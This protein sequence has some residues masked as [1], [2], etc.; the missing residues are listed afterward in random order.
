[1][2][3]AWNEYSD[4]HINTVPVPVQTGLA[5]GMVVYSWGVETMEEVGGEGL[6]SLQNL[7]FPAS[8]GAVSI[9]VLGLRHLRLSQVGPR[10]SELLSSGPVAARMID[11]QV[12]G[13][14]L[15]DDVPHVR[16]PVFMDQIR[17][18]IRILTAIDRKRWAWLGVLRVEPMVAAAAGY[19]VSEKD[20]LPAVFE[21]SREA[22]IETALSRMQAALAHR[23]A[24]NDALASTLLQ[25]VKATLAGAPSDSVNKLAYSR[26]QVFDALYSSDK[27]L[28]G[29]H[30]ALAKAEDRAR[31]QDVLDLHAATPRSHEEIVARSHRDRAQLLAALG[32]ETGG[33]FG[34][35]R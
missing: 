2:T 8:M 13:L 18:R 14:W 6:I 24:H 20:L 26:E 32:R 33:D 5:D 10:D 1:M 17:D 27:R 15:I 30:V 16:Y 11:E 7:A 3:D 12:V 31:M 25:A 21:P 4:I 28:G 22:E 9:D 34:D 29:H 35:T 19:E 23:S